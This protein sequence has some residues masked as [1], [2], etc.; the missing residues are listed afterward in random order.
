MGMAVEKLTAQATDKGRFDYS[1]VDV[2]P[3]QLQAMNERFQEQKDLIKLLKMRAAEAGTST[4]GSIDDVVPILLPH[5]AYKSYPESYLSG[6]KWDR[7]TKWLETVSTYPIAGLDT[8]DITD[9]DDWI[10]R[11]QA[12]GHYVTCSSG[13]TG[14][15]AMLVSSAKDIEWSQ[16]DTVQV[17]SWGSG[18]QPNQDRMMAGTGAASAMVPR[19][20]K[21]GA[22]Q[23]AAFGDPEAP[24]FTSPVP[25]ITIGS[26][27]GQI[28]MR[29]KI[30]DGTAR[31]DEIAK[32]EHTA[33]ERQQA[34]DS[35]V[36]LTAEH[37]IANRDRLMMIAGM[38]A[39]LYEVATAIRERGYSAKDFN[40]DN[41]LYVGGGLK[42]S[43]LPSDY[44]EVVYETFNIPSGRQFQMYGMQETNSGMPKCSDSGRYHVPPWVIPIVLD[45]DGDKAL[46]HNYDGEVTGRAGFVDLS[47][48]GRW[49]GVISG[50]QIT[51]SYA[52]C[53]H[54]GNRGP[55]IQDNIGRIKDLVGDDKIGCSGTVDAYVR[56][57]S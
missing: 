38:W 51:L 21:I 55:S 10:D 41:C 24:R 57:V 43:V 39:S 18:V 44:R 15:S 6:G 42:G 35:A 17:F 53:P 45:Q 29:K 31:P 48:D 9:I 34:V 50:D 27:T 30:A 13:T 1:A 25:P 46:P 4:I 47:V 22:A 56:G 54:C 3:L 12:L 5:T 32:F 19:N 20:L 14:K 40:P 7:L 28:V 36:G 16:I 52:P 37:L 2:L 23:F 26:L 33:R 11:L 49:G 8:S